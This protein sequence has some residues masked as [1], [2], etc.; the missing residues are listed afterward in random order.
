MEVVVEE[1]DNMDGCSSDG[2]VYAGVDRMGH[3]M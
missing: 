3:V 2:S 1:S